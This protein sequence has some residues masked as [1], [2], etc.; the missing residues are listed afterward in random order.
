MLGHA[1]VSQTA[2]YLNAERV[3][4][5][6]SMKRYGTSPAW[7]SV[8]KTVETEQ[9]TVSHEDQPSQPQATIN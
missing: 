1:K 6:D 7:Q 9:P 8:A 2:T 5:H 4:L 3:G